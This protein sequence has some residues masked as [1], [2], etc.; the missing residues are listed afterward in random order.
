MGREPC[1]SLFDFYS[2]IITEVLQ[3]LSKFVSLCSYA[4]IYKLYEYTICIYDTLVKD[5]QVSYS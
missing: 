4:R 3:F 5:L 2:S 1:F